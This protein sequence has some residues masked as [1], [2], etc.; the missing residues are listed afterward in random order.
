MALSSP[1][2]SPVAFPQARPRLREDATRHTGATRRREQQQASVLR[3]R[4]SALLRLVL[5]APLLI[6]FVGFA[7]RQGS[8]AEIPVPPTEALI[9]GQILASDGSVLAGGPVGSRTY[10]YAG[11]AGSLLGFTGSIQPDGRYGLEGLE[12][13]LDPLLT[14]GQDVR[15]TLDPTIQATTDRHLAD[16]AIENGADTGSAVVLEVG[17]GRILAAAS[18]PSYDGNQWR[19][20]DAAQMI[21]RPFLEEYEP[22]SVIKPL[23]V[24]AL[25]ESGRLRPHELIEAPMSLRVGNQTFRDVAQHGPLLSVEDV[26]AYSS[27]SGM[28]HLGSRFAAAEM[29]DWLMRFGIGQD[30]DLTTAYTRSGILNPWYRWVPQDQATNSLGQNHSTTALQLAAAYS[31]FANDGIY[32]P[33]RLTEEEELPEPHRVLSTAVA[34][35]VRGMLTHVTE[36]SGLRVAVVPGLDVAAKTGTADKFD[37]ELNRY[38]PGDYSLS[39][40]GMF[41]ATAPEVVL[42]VVLHK[43]DE[44]STSTYTTGPLF[45][46]ISAE[47]VA[48]WDTAP[49]LESYAAGN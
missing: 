15:L 25:L 14:A 16:A 6:A 44:G 8:P 39:V 36:A 5:V 13:V 18:Y 41:P 29:H 46:A 4:R 9:R 38:V 22:G 30:L 20:A 37:A 34:Q 11:M 21:N 24:A 28:I 45:R 17:T 2:S 7:L 10:P 23:I 49:R 1:T 43:P 33:P 31:V 3:L 26:L 42:V 48:S 40:A 12:Y 32:V 19:E 35:E 27:N 47:V